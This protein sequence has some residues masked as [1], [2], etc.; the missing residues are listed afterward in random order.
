MVVRT[1][2][3]KF[4]YRAI[5]LAE[6][7]YDGDS[8]TADID[9]GLKVWVRRAKIRLYAINCPELRGSTR[10]AGLAAR[11][12]LRE[13]LPGDGEILLRTHKDKREKYGRVLGELW[14]QK[15]PQQLVCLNDELLRAGHAVRYIP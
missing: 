5:V 11:D 12:F 6:D 2:P 10:E 7:V 8:V 1:R 9:L 14:I 4:G 13:L 3:T 15:G